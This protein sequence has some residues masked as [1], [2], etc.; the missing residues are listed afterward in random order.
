MASLAAEE[1]AADLTLIVRFVPV[2]MEA[3]MVEMA[4]LEQAQTLYLQAATAA[5]MAAVM[6]AMPVV[7]K[8]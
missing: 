8:L 7:A 3:Q 2:A 6:V 5:R 1:A 4:K